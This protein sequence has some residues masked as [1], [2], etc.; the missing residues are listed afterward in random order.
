MK[1]AAISFETLVHTYQNT[2]RH[3]PL[4]GNNHEARREN[5]K[6]QPNCQF[7]KPKRKTK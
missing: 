1:L 4:N 6:F 7:N 5:M 3:T 2:S